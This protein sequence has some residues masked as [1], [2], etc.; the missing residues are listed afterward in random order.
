MAQ[1]VKAKGQHTCSWTVCTLQK[2]ATESFN[3]PMCMGA[4]EESSAQATIQQ[5]GNSG[6]SKQK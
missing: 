5:P 3:A 4:R 2:L 1:A 6:R